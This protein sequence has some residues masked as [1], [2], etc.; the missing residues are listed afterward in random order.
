MA[1]QEIISTLQHCLNCD[2]GS[3]PAF[4]LELE[5]TSTAL[6]VLSPSGSEWKHSI[7]SLEY[8]ACPLQILD[9]TASII[10]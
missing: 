8:P 7:G 3:T 10:T 4:R 9:F 6:L 2:I 5:L 1:E